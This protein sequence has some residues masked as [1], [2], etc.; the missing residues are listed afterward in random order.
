MTPDDFIRDYGEALKS[1][2]WKNVEH[3]ISNQACITFSTGDVHRGINNIQ[4]AFENN[5]SKIKNEEF[6]IE[7][8]NWLMTDDKVAVYTFEFNWSGRVNDRIVNGK[9][10]GTSVLIKEKNKWKLLTE[11]LGK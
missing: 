1:Q 11:H 8:V 4:V 7:N 6:N 3:L 10:H 9:G 2:K 5:F